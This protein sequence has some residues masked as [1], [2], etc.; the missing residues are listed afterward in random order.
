MIEYIK[1]LGDGAQITFIICSTIIFLSLLA[2]IAWF[3]FLK[4][5]CQKKDIANT[6]LDT[7]KKDKTDSDNKTVLATPQADNGQKAKYEEED[8]A[9]AL[10]KDFFEVTKVKITYPDNKKEEMCDIAVAKELIKEY[11]DILNKK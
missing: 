1:V 11:K 9:K 7:D 4:Y 6:T 5:K 8:R 2:I 3:V 10:I